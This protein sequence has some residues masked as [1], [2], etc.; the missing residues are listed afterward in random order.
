MR[1]SNNQQG[2][3]VIGSSLDALIYCIQNDFTL[4]YTRILL[5]TKI[6]PNIYFLEKKHTQIDLWRCLYYA[7]SL[8]G[9][10]IYADKIDAIRIE[11]THLNIFTKRARKYKLPA[12]KI[13]VFDDHNVSG[14]PSYPTNAHDN[15]YEVRDWFNVRSGMK[16]SHEIIDG[17]DSFV[18]K[19]IFY[20]TDRVD[21]N[22][23]LKDAV[24]ISHLTKEQMDSMEYSTIN[25]RFKTL[26]MMKQA[27][28]R[29][30]RN[31]RDQKDKTKYKYYAIRLE[32]DHR[33]IVHKLRK[34]KTT[35]RIIFNYDSLT[36]IINSPSVDSNA[37]KVLSKYL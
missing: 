1:N 14:I 24:S 29:G 27:G 34:Y 31:G 5:P 15:L 28:I 6:E 37:R 7:L 2:H 20:Y 23:K 25:S 22:H 3:I 4:V 11:D 36:D 35:D 12:N 18:S 8:S 30:T 26:Y 16:H 9:N 10:I 21:G 19:I 17:Q 13:V 33:E 32:H